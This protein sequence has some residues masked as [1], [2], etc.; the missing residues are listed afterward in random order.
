MY[1]LQIM[2]IYIPLSPVKSNYSI[3]YIV[4]IPKLHNS[5]LIPPPLLL[6]TA[7]P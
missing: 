3:S 1:K 6:A 7:L 4:K 5:T 2:V